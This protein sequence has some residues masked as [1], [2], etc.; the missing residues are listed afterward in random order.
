MRVR[1]LSSA[2][3]YAQHPPAINLR[4]VVYDSSEAAS[5]IFPLSNSPHQ[6]HELNPDLPKS[7]KKKILKIPHVHYTTTDVTCLKEIT[8]RASTASSLS[9]F[10][11]RKTQ[12]KKT[13]NEFRQNTSLTPCERHAARLTSADIKVL[14]NTRAGFFLHQCRK[15]CPVTTRNGVRRRNYAIA[16]V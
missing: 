9:S 15:E 7:A 12:S 10:P 13:P 4:G 5:K 16:Y 1:F 11:H 6:Q 3:W 8:Y 2:A 14:V